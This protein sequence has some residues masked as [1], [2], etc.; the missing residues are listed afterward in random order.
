M[1]VDDRRLR[2]R[3]TERGA[4]REDELK[5]FVRFLVPKNAF[6][7]L[8]QPAE[9]DQGRHAGADRR[10]ESFFADPAEAECAEAGLIGDAEQIVAFRK[11]ANGATFSVGEAAFGALHEAAAPGIG[12]GVADGAESRRGRQG[13]RRRRASGREQAPVRTGLGHQA[14]R[15]RTRREWS[16]CLELDCFWPIRCGACGRQDRY[17]PRNQ[18][19][20]EAPA[21]RLRW[22]CL[23]SS[24]LASACPTLIVADVGDLAQ[25]VEQA[26]RLKDA[27]IDADADVGVTGLDFLQRR[28]GREGA[29]GH[30]R[31]RQPPAP[32]GVVDVG[33]ELAH[34]PPNGGGRFVRGRHLQPSCDRSSDYVAR[35]LHFS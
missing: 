25:T 3:A 20:R 31:H 17:G 13:E 26:E 29:L 10:L 18:P 35:R 32:T 24:A 30:D 4:G 34:G 23:G 7:D 28:A 22:I 33:A 2:P 6:G 14:T 27:G 11:R 21:L 1:L 5:I 8:E 9:F 12:R 15:Y 16:P 19:S